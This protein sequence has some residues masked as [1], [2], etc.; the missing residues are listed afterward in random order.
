MKVV[1]A[2]FCLN[3]GFSCLRKLEGQDIFKSSLVDPFCNLRMLVEFQELVLQI[4]AQR[5]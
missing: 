4:L 2:G 5:T 3:T 1:V